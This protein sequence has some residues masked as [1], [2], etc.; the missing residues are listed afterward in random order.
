[1]C[2]G[3]VWRWFPILPPFPSRRR[4]ARVARALVGPAQRLRR[5]SGAA[6]SRR[7]SATAR[8]TQ[9]GDGL[10]EQSVSFLDPLR[11]KFGDAHR[12]V[13]FAPN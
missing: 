6:A 3:V 11:R 5:A 9:L 13:W 12:V 4:S 2:G 7:S 10:V 8:Y 1:M